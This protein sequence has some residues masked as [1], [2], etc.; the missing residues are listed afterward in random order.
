MHKDTRIPVSTAALFT[1]RDVETAWRSL[2]DERI[3]KTRGTR[4]A[5]YSHLVTPLCLTLCDAVDRSPP[6]SPVQ[7]VLQARILEWA[8]CPSPG[9]SNPGMEPGSPAL[10]ADSLPLSHQGSLSGILLNHKKSE[11]MPFV[12]RRMD[13]DIITLGE[14]SQKEKDK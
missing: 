1:R 12:A 10:Q 5:G 7:G 11:I 4:A 3:E 6:G 8:A 14:G 2:W 9:G 13:L